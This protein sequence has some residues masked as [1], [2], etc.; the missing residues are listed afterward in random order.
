MDA[1]IDLVA[2]QITDWI[3]EHVVGHK[4]TCKKIVL[5][6]LSVEGRPDGDVTQAMIPVDH[7]LVGEVEMIVSQISSAA[8]QD[9]NSMSG[10]IQN[11]AI[12]AYYA[13][14]PTFVPR[15]NFRVCPDTSM[16]SSSGSSEPPTEKGLAAQAMRHLEAVMRLSAGTQ[17]MLMSS[18][19]QQ[20]AKLTSAAEAHERQKVDMMLLVQET[21]NEAHG[22]RLKEKEQEANLAVKENLFDWL[23]VAAP[24]LI[25]RI[26]GKQVMP[27]EVRAFALL[28]SF[29]EG[30]TPDQQEFLKSSLQPQQMAVLAEMLGEYEKQKAVHGKINRAASPTENEPPT[31]D[32]R[33]LAPSGEPTSPP[34]PLKIFQQLSKRMGI[35]PS[36]DPVIQAI[37]QRGTDFASR[38]NDADKPK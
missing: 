12:Y 7:G 23:K 38:L 5:R 14:Y 10:P 33:S 37:E 2:S 13:E 18:M 25:N 11:Y 8:Q 20:I 3:R 6:H 21:L 28:S 32:D 27:D 31:S 30:L 24:I 34:P 17:G 1:E 19:S 15:K 9:A 22:R 26:A 16:E 4:L 36:S 35:S 29:L